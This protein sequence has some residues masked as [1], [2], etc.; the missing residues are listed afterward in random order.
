MTVSLA[1]LDVILARVVTRADLIRSLRTRYVTV[2]VPA[3][4]WHLAMH[5]SRVRSMSF[6]A[7]RTMDGFCPA[8]SAGSL[9]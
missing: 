5:L 7:K 1:D 9:H 4:T 6:C 2:R 3:A 8:A